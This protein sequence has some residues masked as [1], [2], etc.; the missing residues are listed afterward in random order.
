MS[1]PAKKSSKSAP[2]TASE[3][4]AARRGIPERSARALLAWKTRRAG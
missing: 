3:K 2:K 4:L 1:K